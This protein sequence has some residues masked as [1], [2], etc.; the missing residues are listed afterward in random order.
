MSFTQSVAE[1]LRVIRWHKTCCKKAALCGLLFG[2]QRLEGAKTYIAT[3]NSDVEAIR[4]S[5]LIDAGFFFSI[6]IYI[7]HLALLFRRCTKCDL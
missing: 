2:A 5:E 4:A 7:N 1:E 6:I 3:F